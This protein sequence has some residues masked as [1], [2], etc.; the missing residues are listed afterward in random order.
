MFSLQ[1]RCPSGLV[2]SYET[3]YRLEIFTINSWFLDCSWEGNTM[4]DWSIWN[5]G[6][7]LDH[8]SNYFQESPGFCTGVQNIFHL[9]IPMI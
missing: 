6:I 7:Y 4:T 1:Q 8:T 2:F 3:K 9:S 5:P